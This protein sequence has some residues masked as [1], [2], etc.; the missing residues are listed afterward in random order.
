MAQVVWQPEK[1]TICTATIIHE[2]FVLTASHCLWWSYPN[3]SSVSPS[4]DQWKETETSNYT[5]VA[6][7][8]QLNGTEKEMGVRR[9]SRRV[10]PHP[11]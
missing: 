3:A 7:T 9:V 11:K 10:L 5:I 8:V 1:L 4:F 6:G 2:R